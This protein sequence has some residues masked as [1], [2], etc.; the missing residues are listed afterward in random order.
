MLVDLNNCRMQ[1]CHNLV[2]NF[3]YSA[4]SSAVA[5]VLCNGQIVFGA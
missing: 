5:Y 4:D 3:V 2:S 1:P